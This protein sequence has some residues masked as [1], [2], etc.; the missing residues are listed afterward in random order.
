ME[1][2]RESSQLFQFVISYRRDAPSG[3]SDGEER[4]V[5]SLIDTITGVLRS[6]TPYEQSFASL[7]EETYRLRKLFLQLLERRDLS[8]PDSPNRIEEVRK[9]LV[10]SN[11]YPELMASVEGAFVSF[12]PLNERTLGNVETHS[13][14]TKLQELNIPLTYAE[15]LSKLEAV[16]LLEGDQEIAKGWI[17]SNLLFEI[18]LVA[19]SLVLNEQEGM[20]ITHR[21][22]LELGQVLSDQVERMLAYGGLVGMYELDPKDV[23][24]RTVRI[25][26]LISI[27]QLNAGFG[28]VLPFEELNALNDSYAA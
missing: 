16:I 26:I 21:R 1:A 6:S 4:E 19:T 23:T 27:L 9:D 24:P 13:G 28:Q 7:K 11:K 5:Q 15:L 14:G 25:R 20:R 10:A 2:L 18:A 8:K 17:D 3:L 12:A 22:S